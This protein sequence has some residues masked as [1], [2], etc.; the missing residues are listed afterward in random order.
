MRVDRQSDV[1]RIR[2]HLD[3]ERD[4]RNQVAGIGAD[5][6]AADHAVAH[7]VEQ[8]L[9]ESFL[10]PDRQ[11]SP[12]GRPRKDRLLA[13]DAPRLRVGLGETD[14]R[15]L[16]I[17]VGDRRNHAGI[18]VALESCGGLGR[19]LALVSSLVR[20]HGLADDV[21]DRADVRHVRAHLPVD[22]N[23][24]AFIHQDPRGIRGDAAAV[25]GATDR[26]Q[27]LAVEL[28]LGRA[29]PLERDAQAVRSRLYGSG[30]GT[31]HD[32]LEPRGD[33]PL[34]RADQVPVAARNQAIG[35][36]DHAHLHAERGVDGRHLEANDAATD[37][38]HPGWQVEFQRSGRVDHPRV[39]GKAGKADRLRAGRDDAPIEAQAPHAIPAGD[40]KLVRRGEPRIATD[41]RDLALAGQRLEPAGESRNDR[42]LPL[43]KPGSIDLRLAETDA[44]LGHLARLLHDPGRV[45]QGLRRNTT[46]IEA[47]ATQR[48]PALDQHDIEAEVRGA[49]RGGVTARTGTQ[50]SEVEIV[51]MLA[52]R[53]RRRGPGRDRRRRHTRRARRG[54]RHGLQRDGVE[55]GLAAIWFRD[56]HCRVLSGYSGIV[57]SSFQRDDRGAFADAVADLDQQSLDDPCDRGWHVHCGLVALESDERCLG[58]DAITGLHQ[59][60]DD[61]NV[62]EVPEVG[63]RD[64]PRVFR[65]SGGLAQALTP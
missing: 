43:A 22:R 38:Q 35:H 4:L 62:L 21:A 13:G 54:F 49:E 58:L 51:G 39:V 42:V 20:Q 60:F 19:N 61:R 37:D 46:D 28:G 29:F 8:Q 47:D 27:D 23:E 59:H 30:A 32:A 6:P 2:A 16:G 44:V 33:P 5:D 17:G 34:Q 56:A 1:G 55:V 12:A 41:H 45:Q 31:E 48:R 9:G 36:L 14:P 3:R 26:H 18:E 57:C 40:R 24:S 11:R 25:R 10:A 7:R 65:R 64:D 63:N 15:D 52:G 53:S 50:H